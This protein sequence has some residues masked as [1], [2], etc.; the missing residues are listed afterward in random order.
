MK[1]P[2]PLEL[3]NAGVIRRVQENHVHSLELS[4]GPLGENLLLEHFGHLRDPDATEA[5]A[6][7]EVSHDAAEDA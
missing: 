6:R 2:A 1:Q 5:D 7:S 4:Q 3:V